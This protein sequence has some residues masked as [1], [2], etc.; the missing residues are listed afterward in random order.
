MV[1]D[2]IYRIAR[3]VLRN[4]FQ[5]A[6]ASRIEAAIQ[7]DPNLFA[8]GSATMERGWIRRFCRKARAPVIGACP[9][10]GSGPSESERKLKLWSERGAGTEVELTVPARIAYGQLQRHEANFDGC[11]P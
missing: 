7:Y 10:F 11:F 2:E 1:Q 9:E 4:A 5:H 6:G 8:Y 3:E